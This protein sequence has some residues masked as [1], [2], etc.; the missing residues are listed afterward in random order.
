[1]PSSN[2]TFTIAKYKNKYVAYDD[3]GFVIIMSQSKKIVKSHLL[4]L[5]Y[6]VK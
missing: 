2:S 3:K 1:M 6:V 5:G 4:S